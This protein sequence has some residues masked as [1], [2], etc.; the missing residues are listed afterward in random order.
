[1]AKILMPDIQI[2]ICDVS[3]AVLAFLC[4]PDVIALSCASSLACLNKNINIVLTS[5]I[6]TIILSIK[7]ITF[8]INTHRNT[9]IS[10]ICGIVFVEFLSFVV[11]ISLFTLL[12]RMVRIV[13]QSLGRAAER[14]RKVS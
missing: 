9:N 7:T 5:S 6:L 4:R 1:M 12:I 14:N 13:F 3:R 2:F 11:M 8:F 10:V